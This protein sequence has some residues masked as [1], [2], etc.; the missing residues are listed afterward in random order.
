MAPKQKNRNARFGRSGGHSPS[1]RLSRS[2]LNGEPSNLESA[3]RVRVAVALV[4]GDARFERL[5]PQ[6]NLD[7]RPF[8]LR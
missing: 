3:A 7:L 5:M 2:R 6:R 1:V 4:K 8:S